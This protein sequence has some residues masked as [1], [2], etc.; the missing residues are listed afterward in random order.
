MTKLHTIIVFLLLSPSLFA[1]K[2][3]TKVYTDY[4]GYYQSDINAPKPQGSHNVIGFTWEG[5]TFS[6][7]VN[8]SIMNLNHQSVINQIFK[9]FPTDS[10][11]KPLFSIAN[12][13][14][15]NNVGLGVSPD[16]MP[17]YTGYK[18]SDFRY[19]LGD[20][21]NG[22]DIGT[23]IFNINL[24]DKTMKFNNIS[25][26]LSSIGDSIPDIL[27]TQIGNVPPTAKTDKYSFSSLANASVGTTYD[28]KF[29]SDVKRNLYNNVYYFY[30][31]HFNSTVANNDDV[32]VDKEI[33][34]NERIKGDNHRPIQM[35]AL[36]WSELGINEN[37]YHLVYSFN[38][39]YSGDSD[40][41]FIAYNN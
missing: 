22:L 15:G 14:S 12:S 27:I 41:A 37:N 21:I 25:I 36:D 2:F 31:L 34:F 13:Y 10:L 39:L 38:Q 23:G 26:S 30:R 33:L 9:A 40:T 1:Q 8:D 19:Y 35:L 11:A 18:K 32:D 16:D 24:K 3:V 29:G 20:G 28:V 4:N 5:Q 17:T 6:T 7:G